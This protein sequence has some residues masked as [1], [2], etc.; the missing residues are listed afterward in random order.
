MQV[1]S[2]ILERR[3]R[4]AA[5]RGSAV[6]GLVVAAHMIAAGVTAPERQVLQ[7]RPVRVDLAAIG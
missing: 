5:E 2:R 4:D 1:S 7:I 6:A 3:G